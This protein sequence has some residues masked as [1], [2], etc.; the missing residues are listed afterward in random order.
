LAIEPSEENRRRLNRRRAHLK[1]SGASA[2]GATIQTYLRFA[3]GLIIHGG[4]HEPDH[5]SDPRDELRRLRP[6]RST[7]ARRL[8]GVRVGVVTVGSAAPSY[9]PSITDG[10]AIFA[11]ITRAGYSP[12][13]A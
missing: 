1:L 6:Q 3:T 12:Q 13:A 4:E 9:D 8:P 2:A 11:S 5:H 10:D 7:G